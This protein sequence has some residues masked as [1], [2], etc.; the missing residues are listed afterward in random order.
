MLKCWQVYDV[1]PIKVGPFLESG[2]VPFLLAPIWLLYGYL[3]PLLD[4]FFAD[5]AAV[6]EANKRAS[7]LPFVAL[8]WSLC[9]AQFILSD[10]LYLQDFP[11]WQVFNRKLTSAVYL[12]RST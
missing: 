3:Y 6:K 11:H 7:R 9:A 12:K 8:T 1:W 2:L 10:I 5:D 4:E